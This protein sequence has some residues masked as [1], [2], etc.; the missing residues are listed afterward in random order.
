M[1]LN[2]ISVKKSCEKDLVN[3]KGQDGIEFNRSMKGMC[4]V[5]LM[6]CQ[7]NVPYFGSGAE[8][9]SMLLRQLSALVY[10]TA[11]AMVMLAV[12]TFP[13]F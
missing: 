2:E 1:Y 13:R 11:I 12:I 7:R 10:V 3:Q 4:V 8:M 6:C 5:R 9:Q